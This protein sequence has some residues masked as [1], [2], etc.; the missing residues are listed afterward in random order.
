MNKLD[1]YKVKQV[2]IDFT[3][4]EAWIYSRKKVKDSKCENCGK[5]HADCNG[6]IALATIEGRVNAHLCE[7]CGNYFIAKGAVDINRSITKNAGIKEKLIKQ[8]DRLA[9]SKNYWYKKNNE[10]SIN[11][12]K[13]RISGC[14]KDERDEFHT[15]L[16]YPHLDILKEFVDALNDDKEHYQYSYFEAFKETPE[17]LWDYDSDDNYDHHRWCSYF[18]ATK[19]V[20]GKVFSYGWANAKGDNS[21]EDAGF[22]AKDVWDSMSVIVPKKDLGSHEDLCIEFGEYC[23]DNYL[24]DQLSFKELYSKFLKNRNEKS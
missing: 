14:I 18:S 7:D 1:K 5:L 2:R 23:I 6:E 9:P 19:K 21:L 24:D 8:A 13:E 11:E 15:F 17:S 22:Y 3:T 4:K 12:L 20:G 16:K 10:L